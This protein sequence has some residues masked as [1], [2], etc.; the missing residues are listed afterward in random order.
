MQLIDR[1]LTAF[2][3]PENRFLYP[4]QYIAVQLIFK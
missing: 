2:Q 3:L 4:E 1:T